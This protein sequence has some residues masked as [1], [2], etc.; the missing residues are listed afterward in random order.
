MDTPELPGG[1]TSAVA[2][3]IEKV[4]QVEQDV[5][6]ARSF[7]VAISEKIGSFIGT[8]WFVAVHLVGYVLW[9]AINAGIIR[10]LPIFD[11]W[12]HPVLAS[13]TSME[14]VIIAAFV[15]MKQNRAGTL[16]DRRNHLDLQI[17]LLTELEVAQ[18][19]KM[20]ERI[21]QHLG[22]PQDPAER[23]PKF[24]RDTLEHLVD[25]L[26]RR[27]PEVRLAYRGSD[28]S[29]VAPPKACRNPLRPAR[30]AH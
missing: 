22:V 11:P 17:N 14:A 7:G 16:A 2:E 21:E 23:D 4:I 25:E 6:Q 26:G 24:R 12:P 5:V 30:A 15:L 3:N 13:I 10:S 27:L 9:I 18:T 29:S 19:L 20:L 28:L 8:I 1:E